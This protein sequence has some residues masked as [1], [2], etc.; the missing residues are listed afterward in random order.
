MSFECVRYFKEVESNGD[1]MNEEADLSAFEDENMIERRRVKKIKNKRG[2]AFKDCLKLIMM[3]TALVV[4]I[5]L[6]M[7]VQRLSDVSV[8]ELNKFEIETTDVVGLGSQ[9]II[10]K[11]TSL[12]FNSPLPQFSY[13]I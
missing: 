1:K 7:M 13:N 6:I 12:I 8:E 5:L 10:C 3:L 4:Y 2:N 9:T 11:L